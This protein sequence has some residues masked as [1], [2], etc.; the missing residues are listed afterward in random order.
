MTMRL[1]RSIFVAS[2]AFLAACSGNAED[3]ASTSSALEPYAPAG[4]GGAATGSSSW[5]APLPCRNDPIRCAP[6]E[7]RLLI[8]GPDAFATEMQRLRQ[9]KAGTGMSAFALTME[10]VRAYPG[11]DDAEKLK[12]VI[13]RM[14]EEKGTWYVLLAG[15]A[16][17][18]PVRR[19]RVG[20]GNNLKEAIDATYNPSDLYYANLYHHDGARAGTFDDW[21][22]NG[23]G[24]FNEQ[25]WELPP[26]T[27]NPDDVDGYPDVAVG[28]VPAHLSSEL[29]IYV[30][31]VIR[32]ETGQVGPFDGIVRAAS[33]ADKNLTDSTKWLEYY[34]SKTYLAGSVYHYEVNGDVNGPPPGWA[35]ASVSMVDSL[36]YTMPWI[37]YFGHGAPSMFGVSDMTGTLDA[38]H[39]RALSNQSLPIVFAAS[40]ETG[41]FTDN[42]GDPGE[43]WLDANG[44]V[45]RYWLDWQTKTVQDDFGSAS[46][47]QLVVPQPHLYDPTWWSSRSMASAW[48]FPESR[49]GAIAFFGATVVHQG[50]RGLDLQTAILNAY[51][52][53]YRV[54]GDLWADGSRDYWARHRADAHQLGNA[55][56]FLGIQTLFGDPSLRLR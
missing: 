45:H 39:V 27:Y 49:G 20:A 18:V 7:S 19:R 25:E 33:L 53:G 2:F 32:Y 42:A 54:L 26:A 41:R 5:S 24:W 34:E 12:R 37:T 51:G 23:N 46:P 28:R 6:A 21:D 9:H 47:M 44:S 50:V 35:S 4:A 1:Q 13:A 38:A 36:T 22:A 48:L 3:A 31:K 16:S 17:A 56:L 55:R 30:D 10:A 43:M 11:R 29:A 15:D 52:K 8:V 14:H 40:C